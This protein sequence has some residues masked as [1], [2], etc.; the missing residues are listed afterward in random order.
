MNIKVLIDKQQVSIVAGAPEPPPG[1]DDTELSKR[2]G[3]P[4]GAGSGFDMAASCKLG[5]S[6]NVTSGGIARGVPL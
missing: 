6:L 1:Q 4:V 3:I 5:K 2:I